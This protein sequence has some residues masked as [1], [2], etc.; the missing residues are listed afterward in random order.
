[1]VTYFP[2]H[3]SVEQDM[4]CTVG[5]V[6]MNSKATFCYGHINVGWSEKNYIYLPRGLAKSDDY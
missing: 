5:E 1:M 4:L 6:K 2:S 3:K